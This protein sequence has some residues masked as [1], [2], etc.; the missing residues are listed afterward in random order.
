MS[1]TARPPEGRATARPPHIVLLMADQLAPHF[2]P[3]HGHPVVQAPALATLAAQ[4]TVFDQAY[5]NFPICAPSRASMLAGRMPHAL[6]VYDNASEFVSEIPTLAHYLAAAGYRTILSGKMHFVGPDQ[7]HGYHERLTTDIYPADF[8]WVPDWSQGA[9]FKPTGV[10]MGHV[11]DAGP[12]LRNMQIDYDEEVAHCAVQRIWDLARSGP[13]EPVFLT[14]SFTHPHPPFV[15]PQE[16]WDAIDPASIDEPL[17]AEIAYEALDPHSQWLYVAHGQDR[18]RIDAERLRRA[19]RA[20]YAMIRYVDRKIGQV[21]SA[22]DASGLGRDSVVVFCTDHGEMMGER[23]MWFKQTFYEPSVRV[24]LTIRMPESA[25]TAA[26]HRCATPCS[27]VDLLPTLLDLVAHAPGGAR[28]DPVD[29]LDGRSLR[30]ALL[31]EPMTTA[32]V[33]S[34]YSSEG[35]CAASRMIRR[36]QW[37]YIFTPG[38]PPLLF[39][40][41]ADPLELHDRAGDPSLAAIARSLHERLIADWPPEV[42]DRSIR[43]SQRRRLFLRSLGMQTGQWPAWTHAV[44]PGDPQRYVRPSTAGGPVGPKPRMRYPFVPPTPPDA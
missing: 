10:G 36:D 16:D 3:F 27:L 14:V 6:G 13:A 33:F 34:E 11:V 38:L 20:Y 30:P 7:L 21:L 24:P 26:A 18:H 44:R 32:D 8:L 9:G 19:R 5:C 37:K 17:V 4:S 31:G 12:S 41:A 35:V 43:D 40:L 39:D 25:R 22:L 2:L 42:I 28:I 29:R 15:A 1:A 23:G